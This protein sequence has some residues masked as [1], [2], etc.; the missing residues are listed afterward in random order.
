L[1]RF[2]FRQDGHLTLRVSQDGE[3]GNKSLAYLHDHVVHRA[4][5]P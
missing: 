5:R 4:K 2:A 3:L 1:G